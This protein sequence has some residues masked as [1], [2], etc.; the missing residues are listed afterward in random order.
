VAPARGT[1]FVVDVREGASDLLGPRGLVTTSGPPCARVRWDGAR[2]FLDAALEAQVFVGGKRVDGEVEL[3]PGD[4]VEV[5]SHHLVVGVAAPF[6][7]PQRR[8]FT[9][10]ELVERIGEELARAARAW[11]PTALAMVR[12]IGRASCRERV[13]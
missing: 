3:A 6:L 1:T 4:Y 7:S 5:Q 12:E 2:L 10:G 8:S 11:R 9:H 13:S